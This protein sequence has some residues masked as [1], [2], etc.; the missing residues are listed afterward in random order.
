MLADTSSAPAGNTL[1]T[2]PAA[3]ELASLIADPMFAKS[4]AAFATYSGAAIRYDIPLP[5]ASLE[6]VRLPM[7]NAA[8][9]D[10]I[11]DPG[12]AGAFQVNF[13]PR[14]R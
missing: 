3:A 13:R 4:V 11:P 8:A 5:R 7:T 10:A 12:F 9:T 6:V 1:D 14:L 2:G